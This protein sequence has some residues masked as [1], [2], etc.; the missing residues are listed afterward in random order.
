MLLL[1]FKRI[2]KLS[3]KIEDPRRKWGNKRHELEDILVIALLTFMAGGETWED[4]NIMGRAKQGMLRKVLGLRNGVPSPDTFRRVISR[5]EPGVL[6]SLYREWVRPYVGSNLGKQISIDGKT[7]RG[8]SKAG[9]NPLHLVS[10]WVRED[11]ISLGQLKVAEKAN[12]ITAIPLLLDSLNVEGGTVTI[13]AIGC[14]KAI[15]EKI[16]ERGANYLLSVKQNQPTMYEAVAEYFDWALKDEQEREM[17]SVYIS[18]KELEH[19]RSCIWKA[20]VTTDVDWFYAKKDWRQLRAFVMVERTRSTKDGTSSEKAYYISS[21][22]TDAKTMLKL[23]RGHW[24]I[25]NQLHWM[26]DV[27]F[28]EDKCLIR[29][30]FAPQ[31]LSLLRKLAMAILK[32]DQEHKYSLRGK[33][34]L[35]GWSD[36][37]A[38]S[39]LAS[40]AS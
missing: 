17:L 14:Q 32:T 11:R 3:R 31:N 33:K 25:E 22:D 13:D 39:M 16:I 28:G 12:E 7:V 19:D 6:E 4:M 10:A 18:P 15:A 5:L 36:E 20:Y 26:L 24:A 21:L 29:K 8:A 9:D 1:N 23:S 2:R 27:S 37:Y 35:V 40:D 30:D 38:F 34:K